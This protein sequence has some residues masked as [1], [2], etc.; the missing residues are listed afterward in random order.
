MSSK[1]AERAPED[2][3]RSGDRF[4]AELRSVAVCTVGE[5]FG[6]V[7]RHVLELIQG[8]RDEGIATALIVFHHGELADQARGLGF[9]VLVLPDSNAQI[10]FTSHK[11]AKILLGRR[12]EVLH[13]H[14]YKATTV[15]ALSRLWVRIP[16]VKT[17]HGLPEPSLRTVVGALRDRA[18]HFS[19]HIATLAACRAVA[20]VTQDLRDRYR[21]DR[22]RLR[23]LVIP[24]GIAP[25]NPADFP[26]PPEFSPDELNLVIIGRLDRV[27][28]IQFAVEALAADDLPAHVRLHVIGTG[29]C[30]GELEELA[31]SLGLS[32]RVRFLGFRK[33]VFQFLAHSTAL[34]MPSLH[35]GLPFTL[36]ESMALGI[37][38]I[39]SRVG[40]LAEVLQ[41]NLTAL[42]VPPADPAALAQAIARLCADPTLASQLR[43]RSYD[44]Y[45]AHYSRKVMTDRYMELYRDVLPRSNSLSGLR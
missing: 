34:L 39:A 43:R 7:E 12:V 28:G 15:G 22:A 21:G 30:R 20:Y 17:A 42:L 13:V 25:L 24:N 27:K 8:L 16:V 5:L 26:P 18:Y 9:D 32:T 36:L 10:L 1:L 11:L 29:P 14:G 23:E 37:P 4:A 6:G 31:R 33:N 19:E 2:G 35:E 44:V 45:A 41:H 38:V 3:G 40:G